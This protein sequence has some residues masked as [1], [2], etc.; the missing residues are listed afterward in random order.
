MTKKPIECDAPVHIAP[1]IF[2]ATVSLGR[3]AWSISGTA[4]VWYADT[5]FTRF[6][7]YLSVLISRAPFLARMPLK[8]M[9]EKPVECNAVFLWRLGF[10]TPRREEGLVD[11]RDWLWYVNICSSGRELRLSLEVLLDINL[12][13]NRKGRHYEN[14]PLSAASPPIFD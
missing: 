9:T 10:W 8:I 6:E 3:K 2:K 4:D 14:S 11:S 5:W 12:F 13:I 1:K 7:S